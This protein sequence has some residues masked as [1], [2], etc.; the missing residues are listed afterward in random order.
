MTLVLLLTFAAN[1]AA[2]QLFI[3]PQKFRVSKGD[4]VVIGFHLADGFP[5]SALVLKRL[6]APTTWTP[7]GPMAIAN[8]R[9]Q[10][11]RLVSTILVPG[12]GHILVT[13]IVPPGTSTLKAGP[14]LKYLQ[15]EGFTDIIEMRAQRG[16]ADKPAKERF[17]MYAKAILLAGAPDE[18]Y[19]AVVGH[20]FE[21]VPEKDPY[22]LMPGE[23]LPVR[24][25]LRGAP[26][27]NV[28][29]GAVTVGGKEIS[30]G[31]TNNEGRISV[32][33]TAGKWR[34]RA[35]HIERSTKPDAD[36]ESFWATLT[37]ETGSPVK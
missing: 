17:A 25:M 30:V 33:L 3:M 31:K 16:E 26:A 36:W 5:D 14:F 28:N 11:K 12:A 18:A 13:G 7:A 23:S 2:H 35:L 22:R 10:G 1:A 6:D 20:P 32:P 27:R 4:P 8:V 19:K 37:F 29:V 9:T 24:L 21:I 34:L 15:E